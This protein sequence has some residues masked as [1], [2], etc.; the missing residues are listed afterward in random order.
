MA[1]VAQEIGPACHPKLTPR[2]DRYCRSYSPL[3]T[4]FRTV[5]PAFFASLTDTLS[6]VGALNVEMILRTGFRQA[7][8]C[9]NGAAFSGRRRVNR[10]PQAVQLPSHNSYSYSGID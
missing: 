9:V 5:K 3:L 7:G 2:K 8:Q 10:P 4:R 1:P 6:F